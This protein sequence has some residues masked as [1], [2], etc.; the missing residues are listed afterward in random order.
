M[1]GKMKLKKAYKTQILLY[2]KIQQTLNYSHMATGTSKSLLAVSG[3]SHCGSVTKL[4]AP[5]PVQTV[6]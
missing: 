5:A 2:Y 1:T 6:L 3:L 4:P